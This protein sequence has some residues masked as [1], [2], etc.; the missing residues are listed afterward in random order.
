MSRNALY[1][2]LAIVVILGLAIWV[3][4]YGDNR[5]ASTPPASSS[6]SSGTSTGQSGTASTPAPPSQPPAK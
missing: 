3:F 1:G 2:I 5:V 6:T 4:G